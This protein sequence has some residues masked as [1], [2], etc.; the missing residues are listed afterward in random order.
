MATVTTFAK[1]QNL[2]GESPFWNQDRLSVFWVEIEEGILHEKKLHQEEQRS[3]DVGQKI[4]VILSF[5]DDEVLLGSLDGIIKFHLITE[6]IT[7]VQPLETGIST[8]RCNDGAFDVYGNIWIGTMD[9]EVKE[10]FG[11]LYQISERGLVNKM[12]DNLSIPNGLVFSLDNTRMYFI[13]TPSKSVK[14]YL[15]EL[16]GNISFEKI[17]IV[18]PED[19]GM[20]DG[21]TIDQDGMLWIALYAGAAIIR[22]NPITGKLINK[23]PLP[24][25]NITNCCFAGP[26][27]EELIVTSARENMT[28]DELNTYRCSGDVFKI[29]DLKVKGVKTLSHKL[30]TTFFQ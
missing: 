15:L 9:L 16:S 25:L 20:P 22:C 21:M 6:K 13:D 14:S 5:E 4:S 8:Q 10:G 24:A 30:S 29:T 17:S 3:W 11:S 23:I 27:L 18:I 28:E 2:L 12:I 26:T 19:M 1:A 7:L